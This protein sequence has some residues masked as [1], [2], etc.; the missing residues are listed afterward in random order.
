MLVVVAQSVSTR[1]RERTSQMPPSSRPRSG[2]C[3]V[4][5]L[6]ASP[7]VVIGALLVAVAVFACAALLVQV[8]SGLVALL[9]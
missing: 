7:Y 6:F 9:P 2:L 1:D 3:V 4:L 8:L 5:W